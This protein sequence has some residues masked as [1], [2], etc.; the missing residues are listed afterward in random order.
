[1]SRQTCNTHHY[2]VIQYIKMKDISYVGGKWKILVFSS[3]LTHSSFVIF[4]LVCRAELKFFRILMEKFR[5][6]SKFSDNTNRKSWVTH[7][8]NWLFLNLLLPN[9]KLSFSLLAYT[10]FIVAQYFTFYT[11][12]SFTT[13]IL[14]NSRP[15]PN[16]LWTVFSSLMEFLE[17]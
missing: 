11:N 4:V 3:F 7:D 8:I 10:L 1:M 15:P 5:V 16:I 14:L 17:Q 9:F 12:F 6:F 13:T 2:D